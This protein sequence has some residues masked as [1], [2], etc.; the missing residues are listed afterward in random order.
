LFGAVE[1]GVCTFDKK[2]KAMVDFI[3]EVKSRNEVLFIFG[4]VCFVFAFVCIAMALLTDVKVLNV[5]AWIKPMKFALATT[6]F[7]WTMAW[8]AHYL[9]DW[10]PSWFNW[11]VVVMLGFEIIYIAWQ[12]GRGEMSHFNVRTPFHNA[13]FG[14]MAFAASAVTLYTGYIAYLFFANDFPELPSHYVWAIRLG[15]ILFV[16]FSFQGF[17]MGSRMA[18]TVG[19]PDGGPGL[20]VLNWSTTLGDA[21][22]AHFV[23]MHALQILPVLSFYVFKSTRMTFVVAFIYLML[24]VFTLEQ[25][26]QGRPLVRAHHRTVSTPL[27]AAQEQ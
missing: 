24:A 14:A 2:G 22:V 7:S 8:F 27:H 10:N 12:A 25:A 11:T 18:H 17:L 5:S 9:H 26:L 20:P 23:G 4:A 1:F 16:V 15:L 19:G 3:H 6:I 21:R 13:M